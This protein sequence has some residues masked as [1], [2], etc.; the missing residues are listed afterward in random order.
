MTR[1]AILEAAG[2]LYVERGFSATKLADVAG[3]A[4]VSLATVKVVFGTKRSLLEAVLRARLVDDADTRPLTARE[5]WQQMLAEPDPRALLRRFVTLSS[6]L[7]ARSAALIEAVAKA[8]AADPELAEVARRG[9]RKRHADMRR[10]TAALADRGAL[11]DDLDQAA[12]ADIIWALAAPSLYLQLVADR[13]WAP[14]DWAEFVAGAL[15][16]AL[17]APARPADQ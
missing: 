12:A 16:A 17:L 7:H 8:G 2:R 10:V 15:A 5:P 1:A 14:E 6:E 13:G 3:A 9:A 4:D 11:R